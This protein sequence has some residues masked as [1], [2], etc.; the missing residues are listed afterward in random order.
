VLPFIDL[1]SLIQTITG[2]ANPI[3]KDKL[4]RN[5]AVIQILQ[6]FN[7][8]PDLLWQQASF[9]FVVVNAFI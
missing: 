4:L 6:K 9:A 8:A 7:L 1:N 2:I 3:L 5:E